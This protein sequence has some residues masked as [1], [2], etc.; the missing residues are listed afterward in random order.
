MRW[1]DERY[2][3]LYTRDTITWKMLPW[4]GKALLPLL[5]RKVDRAG[6]LDVGEHGPDGLAALVE[7]PVEVVS[8]GL[9]ALV[10]TKT[11]QWTDDGRALFLPNFLRA[12][13]AHQSDA[14]RKRDQRERRAAEAKLDAF[15]LSQNVTDC[16]NSGQEVTAG[17]TESQS[18][19]GGHSE[20][21]LAEPSLAVVPTGAPEGAAQESL[22]LVESPAPKP[23][24]PKK[25]KKPN[26]QFE[27]VAFYEQQWVKAFKPEDG[28]PPP[29][30]DAMWGHASKLIKDSDL[31]TAMKYVVLFIADPD[32][33]IASRG[34]RFVDIASRVAAYKKAAQ[35][36][37]VK[38]A[39][40]LSSSMSDETR[41]ALK[42]IGF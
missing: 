41:E 11:A 25:P 4:Q 12:Q 8:E 27:L 23:K 9:A 26:E 35:A 31:P 5:M 29:R 16:P 19:T 22:R 34:H 17:H 3:R 13:E 39:L 37:P 32:R 14:Q 28:K 20:P 2:V 10:K 15:G 42:K 18:V 21:S 24:K 38:G 36:P 1:E 30:E 7:L 33:H 40:P 6:L